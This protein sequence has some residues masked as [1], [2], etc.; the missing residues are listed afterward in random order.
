[1]HHSI[2]RINHQFS[3]SPHLHAVINVIEGN[4][5][6]LGKSAGLTEHLCLCHHAGCC[7]RTVILSAHCS[8]EI[9]VFRLVKPDKGMTGNSSKANHH[10][11]MLNRIILIKQSRS[12][13]AYLRTLAESQHLLKKAGRHNLCVII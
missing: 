1:M 3:Q 7:H 5:Q 4:R 13:N 11:G 2:R 10:P 8:V 12:H 9:A 6:L